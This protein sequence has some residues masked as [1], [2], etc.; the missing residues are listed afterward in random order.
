M[1]FSQWLAENVPIERRIPAND[2]TNQVIKL[3]EKDK[4]VDMCI[5]VDG[6]PDSA[7]IIQPCKAGQWSVLKKEKSKGWNKLCDYLILWETQGKIFAVFVELKTTSPHGKGKVQLHWTLPML[8]YLLYV[9][10]ADQGTATN[11]TK[12]PVSKHFIEI[13]DKKN[14][15]LVKPQTK[16]SSDLFFQSSPFKDIQVHYSTERK[17]SLREFLI[18]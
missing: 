16:P 18:S 14:E 9:F 5:K 4:N 13:G 10:D 6:I 15:R 2:W 1:D 11:S 17:F 8:Y 12:R 3:R 7:V